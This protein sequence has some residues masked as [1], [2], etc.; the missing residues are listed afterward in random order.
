VTLFMLEKIHIDFSLLLFDYH[1]DM[2][3][4]TCGKLLSWLLF[5]PRKK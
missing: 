1:S 3:D 4:S 5:S 2:Q